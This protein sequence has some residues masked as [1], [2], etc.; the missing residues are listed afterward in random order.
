M[1]KEGNLHGGEWLHK[2]DSL[3][4]ITLWW[5]LVKMIIDMRELYFYQTCLKYNPAHQPPGMHSGF[6]L[7][8]Y[9]LFHL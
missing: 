8:F 7:V 5:P 6:H 9:P 1:N 2:R 4:S 3:V